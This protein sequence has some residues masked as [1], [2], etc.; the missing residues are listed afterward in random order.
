MEI[1]Q[2]KQTEQNI[3]ELVKKTAE[4]K[5]L[6]LGEDVRKKYNVTILQGVQG[7]NYLVCYYQT[8]EDIHKHDIVGP[9]DTF[10]RA[11]CM[12]KALIQ[13]RVVSFRIDENIPKEVLFLNFDIA[14]TVACEMIKEPI[15]F[16]KDENETW[17]VLEQPKL[18]GITVPRGTIENSPLKQRIIEAMERDYL[19]NRYFSAMQFSNFLQ[20]L[21]LYNI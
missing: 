8:M 2:L 20:L 21:Y 13:E 6:E 9:A 14:F 15:T 10:I 19:N 17:I 1:R 3:D 11:S 18:K 7:D 4:K 12:C 5:V 16:K